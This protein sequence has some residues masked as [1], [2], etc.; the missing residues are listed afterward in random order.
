MTP[1]KSK[2]NPHPQF[3]SKIHEKA[4]KGANFQGCKILFYCLR[5]CDLVGDLL[6]PSVQT[7]GGQFGVVYL[8][9]YETIHLSAL[10]IFGF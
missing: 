7:G 10:G 4:L 5:L 9:E 6:G 3:F 8:V 1:E 2:T